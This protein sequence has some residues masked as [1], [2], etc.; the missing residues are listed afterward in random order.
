MSS[1]LYQ[2]CN[3]RRALCLRNI[4]ITDKWTKFVKVHLL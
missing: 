4:F 1:V 3:G 2:R